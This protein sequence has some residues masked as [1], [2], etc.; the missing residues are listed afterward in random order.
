L[1]RDFSSVL[2]RT[3]EMSVKWLNNLH[4]PNFILVC[5]G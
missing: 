5:S 4:C 2:G 3:V 1:E